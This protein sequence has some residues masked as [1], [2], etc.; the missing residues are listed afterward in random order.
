[1]FNLSVKVVIYTDYSNCYTLCVTLSLISYVHPICLVLS[2]TLTRCRRFCIVI[3]TYCFVVIYDFYVA[4]SPMPYA[5]PTFLVLFSLLTT[6]AAF[7]VL[8]VTLSPMPYMQ[9][10]RLVMSPTLTVCRLFCV[11]I[12]TDY[13]SPFM[14]FV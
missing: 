14:P 3:H 6:Y 12:Y 9:P 5:Q 4:L 11:V 13:K 2:P 10:T 8:Y 7:F 1:M